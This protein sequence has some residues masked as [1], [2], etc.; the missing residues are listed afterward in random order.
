MGTVLFILAVAGI[1][2][3]LAYRARTATTSHPRG[4][5]APDSIPQRLL[6]VDE[7]L[8]RPGWDVAAA[9]APSNPKPIDASLKLHYRDA[10]GTTTIRVVQAQECDTTNPEGYLIGYCELRQDIRT[11]RIDRIQRAI[12][13]ATGEIID[14]LCAFAEASFKASPAHSIIQLL[15]DSADALRG[16]FYIGKADGRFTKKEK[17]LFLAF[18]HHASGDARITIKQIEDACAYL[19]QPSM[20][21]YKLICGR[22]A[23]ASDELKAGVL[24]TAEAMIATEKTVAPEEVEALA[25]MRKRFVTT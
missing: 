22:L 13:M 15:D 19:P 14:D 2:V 23:Q 9:Y 7:A 4:W 12:D 21:A 25:Y 20:Q 3:Y 1:V 16:L 18:C 6:A 5:D 11:F 10:S 17:E 24:Q 8:D